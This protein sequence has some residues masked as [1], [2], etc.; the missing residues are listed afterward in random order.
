MSPTSSNSDALLQKQEREGYLNQ[1]I[2]RIDENENE[3]N[4]AYDIVPNIH[5]YGYSKRTPDHKN[6]NISSS[7]GFKKRL[8]DRMTP[9][10]KLNSNEEN[11]GFK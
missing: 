7:S 3:S 8:I 1:S 10:F 4:D 5:Q 2:G 6:E 9:E 11:V